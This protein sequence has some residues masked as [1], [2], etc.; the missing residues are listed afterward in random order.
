MADRRSW[1]YNRDI[2]ERCVSNI[3]PRG[4]A[5]VGV[6]GGHRCAAVCE[7]ERP[8]LDTAEVESTHS[9]RE[10]TCSL[11]SDRVEVEAGDQVER[12]GVTIRKGR[13]C[14]I[15]KRLG[16]TGPSQTHR[17]V[18]DTTS[19]VPHLQCAC[20]AACCG[21]GETEIGT[22]GCRRN[23]RRVVYRE[24]RGRGIRVRFTDKHQ[25][26]VAGALAA[27]Y[28]YVEGGRIDRVGI[29]TK[30]ARVAAQG[31]LEGSRRRR[32]QRSG[33]ERRRTYEDRNKFG[34]K[35][36]DVPFSPAE[37]RTAPYRGTARIHA[38]FGPTPIR[39][40]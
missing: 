10:P 20:G 38:T 15:H 18:R 39:F 14:P 8:G 25:Q 6:W 7:H 32:E 21:D 2:G 22:G 34:F 12:V 13:R 37:A 9:V 16:I 26:R 29:P 27:L 30:R 31:D 4:G 23:S 3:V 24:H 33:A 28:L 17:V 19:K 11:D 1:Y 5:L 36:I 40:G 35:H